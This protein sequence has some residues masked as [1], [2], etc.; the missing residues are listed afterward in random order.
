MKPL[1]FDWAI[2]SKCN[3]S[4]LHCR[5]MP[6]NELSTN[7]ILKIAYELV[8]L[9][10]GWV[11][12]EGGEPLLKAELWE[13]LNILIPNGLEVSLI[14]NGTLLT[15]ENIGKIVKAGVDV[16][17]SIDSPVPAVYEQIRKGANFMQVVRNAKNLA[18][19]SRL[20]A[21]N[22]VLSKNNYK[23][24]PQMFE[25][26]KE[27][28]VNLINILGLKPLRTRNSAGV[29]EFATSSYKAQLLSPQEY[30][31]AIISACES[32]EKYD[33]KFFFDEPFFNVACRELGQNIEPFVGTNSIRAHLQKQSKIVV[34]EIS[35]CIFG[36]YLFMEPNGDLKPCTFA[37]YVVGNEKDGIRKTWETVVCRSRFLSAIKE[38]RKGKCKKCKYFN[39]CG[40]CRS[41]VYALTHDWF[42][43]DPACPII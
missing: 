4:C 25:L 8:E 24:I 5:G 34:S 26:A 30:K 12:V 38:K 9:K 37:D 11:I 15:Q 2:T 17:V 36:E 31:T 1:L 6:Q 28:G 35:G 39:E 29:L 20:H 16:Q 3:L 18:K 41:R 7:E 40:G 13:V 19:T 42:A 33:I 22:F 21:L 32:G 43:S 14:T 23:N 10:P 27:I